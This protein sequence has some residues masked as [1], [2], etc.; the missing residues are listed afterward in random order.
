MKSL[1]YSVSDIQGYFK[2][3]IKKHEAMRD[4]LRKRTYVNQIENRIKFRKKA[5]YYP[6][7]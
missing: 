7:L 5:R 6:Q 3:I 1:N 4:N 2:H